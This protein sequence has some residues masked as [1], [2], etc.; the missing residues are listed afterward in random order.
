[1]TTRLLSEEARSVIVRPMATRRLMALLLVGLA[2]LALFQPAAQG[3]EPSRS[4]W[5]QLAWNGFLFWMPLILAGLL[6]GRARWVLMAGVMYGTIGLALD[7]STLVQT[8]IHSEPQSRLVIMSVASGLL[9][10]LL[11][12]LGGR[13]FLDVN[14]TGTSRSTPPGAPPPSPPSPSAT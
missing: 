10:F 5:H 14:G 7:I 9:N 4:I 1:M 13:A 12:V 6:F 8:L 3:A 2:I 11:I